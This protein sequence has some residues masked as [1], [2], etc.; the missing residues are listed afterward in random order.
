AGSIM[1]VAMTLLLEGDLRTLH[2]YD[3]FEGMPSPTD[4]DYSLRNNKS[5]SILLAE[6]D[7]SSF[8]WAYAPLEDVYENLRST[9]YPE[10]LIRVVKGRVE[11]TIP[12]HVPEKISLLRL[13]TDWYE[14]TRHEIVHLY[15][16]IS[17]G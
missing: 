12:T 14:S 16:R 1:A 2:L 7:R 17:K 6:S 4:A 15:P 9:G 5:A 3:T 10:H 13:D 11:E 8:V